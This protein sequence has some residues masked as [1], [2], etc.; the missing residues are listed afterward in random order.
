M[1]LNAQD[2]LLEYGNL[3]QKKC[4]SFFDWVQHLVKDTK[5]ISSF[6]GRTG[7]VTQLLIKNEVNS[8]DGFVIEWD[9]SLQKSYVYD[10]IFTSYAVDTSSRG[11]VFFVSE[12]RWNQFK[13][14]H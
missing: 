5:V 7:R 1:L 2:M 14:N 11:L 10:E 9:H 6:T 13:I 8:E 4:P 3:H 12:D